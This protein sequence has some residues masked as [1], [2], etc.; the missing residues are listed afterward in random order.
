MENDSLVTVGKDI[1]RNTNFVEEKLEFARKIIN[2]KKYIQKE[3]K[4]VDKNNS[5]L[6]PQENWMNRNEDKYVERS[7]SDEESE[8]TN[9]VKSDSS[10]SDID[11]IDFCNQ[12]VTSII[13]SMC[14]KPHNDNSYNDSANQFHRDMNPGNEKISLSTALNTCSNNVFT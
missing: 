6:Y 11:E 14:K 9:E 1:L 4:K 2:N 13:Q 10:Y 8:N 7:S 5:Y 3:E 12:D